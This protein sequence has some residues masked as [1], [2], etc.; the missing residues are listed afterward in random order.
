[1]ACINLPSDIKQQYLEKLGRHVI[2]KEELNNI[3]RMI[4]ILESPQDSEADFWEGM[5]TLKKYDQV[6]NTNLVDLFPEFAE[7]Y[8][9]TPEPWIKR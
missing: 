6:R 9:Q 4:K 8:E 5:K 1:M 2:V 7:Y 3:E